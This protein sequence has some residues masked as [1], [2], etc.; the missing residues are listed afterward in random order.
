MVACGGFSYGDVLGAGE[1]WAKINPVFTTGSGIYLRHSSNDPIPSDLV[2]VNGCQMMAS[3]K[4][5]IPGAENWPRF[6]TNR[7]EQFEARFSLVQVLDSPSILFS[8][9]SGSHM[10]IAVSHGEGR[11]DISSADAARLV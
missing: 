4:E 8:G 7:S 5:L 6:V 9:M 1:G 11:A 3:I 10:P 2:S